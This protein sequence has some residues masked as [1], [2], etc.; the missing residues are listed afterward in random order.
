MLNKVG[1]L[2]LTL[3]IHITC[4]AFLLKEDT[5]AVTGGFLLKK[6]ILRISSIFT[7]KHLCWKSLFNKVAGLQ[8]FKPATLLKRGSNAGVLL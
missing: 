1:F 5:G 7:G 3:T 8:A 4:G 2:L 6:N